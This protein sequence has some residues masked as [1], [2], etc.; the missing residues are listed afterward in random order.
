MKI[1]IATMIFCALI[2]ISS[3]VH[4]IIN[5]PMI[6]SPEEIRSRPLETKIVVID[7]CE[8]IESYKLFPAM[9][10]RIHKQNCMF[11]IER[12]SRLH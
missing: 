10:S 5:G 11:C 8:Y 3:I 12:K 6:G 1:L 9:F 7:S 4:V 2:I